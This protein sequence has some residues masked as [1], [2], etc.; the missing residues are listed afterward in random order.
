[1]SAVNTEQARFNMIEQQIRPWDVLDQRV[2]RLF[3]EVPREAFV[4]AAYRNLAFADIE[5]PL[6]QGE[7]MMS[8]KLEGRML[9]A[10]AVQSGDRVLEV[11]TGSGFV[12]ACLARLADEVTSIEIDETLAEQARA[13][14]AEQGADNVVLRSG[15]ALAMAEETNTYDAIAVTG[16]LPL[17]EQAEVFKRSLTLG[18]RLFLILGEA[19]VMQAVLITRVGQDQYTLESLFETELPALRNA[20]QPERFAF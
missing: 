18:G 13:R 5:I 14:L 11:G 1:M 12:T 19:P 4:P 7:T 9:Q 2:L 3:D 20:R 17:E 6:G 15:D 10:L 8:P 16:S